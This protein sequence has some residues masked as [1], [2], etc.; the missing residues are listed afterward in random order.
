MRR[1]EPLSTR[2]GAPD[3]QQPGL[4]QLSSFSA[5]KLLLGLSLAAKLPTAQLAHW[6]QLWLH[7]P[8]R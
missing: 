5:S 1:R 4:V 8:A 3:R 2:R 6:R 7:R